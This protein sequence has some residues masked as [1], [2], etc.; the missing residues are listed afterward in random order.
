MCGV[1]G[2][3]R[4]SQSGWS[5]YTAR[6]PERARLYK[7]PAWKA[8]RQAQLAADPACAICRR[9]ATDADHV[10]A[11]ALGGSFDGPLQSLCRKCHLAKTVRDSHEA[12]KRAAARRKNPR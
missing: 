9:P 11:I 6:H 3:T 2:C 8:R 7:D 5:K 1:V 12:A 4:H 10:V